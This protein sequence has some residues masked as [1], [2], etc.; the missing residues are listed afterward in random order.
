MTTG[1]RAHTESENYTFFA[2]ETHDSQDCVGDPSYHLQ[3]QLGR[4]IKPD[5]CNDI[6]RH[7]A[8]EQHTAA[9]EWNSSH[10][11]TV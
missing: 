7:S 5:A 10:G 4:G 11:E 8:V 2:A 6:E 9:T 3:L 1:M